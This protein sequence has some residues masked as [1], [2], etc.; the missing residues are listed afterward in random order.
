MKL[1]ASTF[2]VGI[3]SA[4]STAEPMAA[5]GA[6]TVQIVNAGGM[7]WSKKRIFIRN[8]PY[9]IEDP[10]PGQADVRIKFAEEAS[11]AK[12]KTMADSPVPGLP[13]AAGFVKVGLKDYKSPYSMD[14]KAYPSRQRRTYHTVDELRQILERKLEE[15][16]RRAMRI[17]VGPGR[18]G[19]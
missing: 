12:D 17:A 5:T 19:L 7:F 8:S 11:K 4:G 15:R 2:M 6:K 14:P 3:L 16:Q 10:H 13:P 18:L 1:R 9:T